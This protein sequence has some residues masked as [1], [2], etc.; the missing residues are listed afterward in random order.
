MS[1][2][3]RT[4]IY[5]VRFGAVCALFALLCVNKLPAA[6]Q[7]LVFYDFEEGSGSTVINHGSMS[8]DGTIMNTA[9][10]ISGTPGI[11]DGGYRFNGLAGAANVN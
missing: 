1:N 2:Q 8:G 6:P 3:K 9:D 7:P 10:W 11:S 5:N 4:V